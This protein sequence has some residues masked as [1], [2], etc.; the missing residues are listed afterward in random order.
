MVQAD[1][2]GTIKPNTV[3]V[4]IHDGQTEQTLVISSDLEENGAV[5]IRKIEY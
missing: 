2:L 3:A 5:L 4:S 1:D